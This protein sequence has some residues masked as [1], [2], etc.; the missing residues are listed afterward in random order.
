MIHL[1]KAIVNPGTQIASILP[2]P[3]PRMWVPGPW[4]CVLYPKGP[5][6]SRHK[7]LAV[8]K[9]QLVDRANEI[10]SKFLPWPGTPSSICKTSKLSCRFYD[11]WNFYLYCTPAMRTFSAVTPVVFWVKCVPIPVIQQDTHPQLKIGRPTPNGGPKLLTHPFSPL[12]H[13]TTGTIWP[14]PYY[15]E[16]LE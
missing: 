13:P 6:A 3:G 2:V 9:D 7:P 4:T 15:T 16:N 11:T 1:Q 8:R 14:V 5:I 12:A 10:F